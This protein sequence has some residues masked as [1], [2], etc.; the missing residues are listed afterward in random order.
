MN[1][2]Y[3]PEYKEWVYEETL[4]NGL[5]VLL[6]PKEDY[7]SSFAYFT[8]KFGGSYYG[9]EVEN[10]TLISGLAHFLEHRLFD[11]PKG[12]VMNLYD[13]LGA[14]T[15][16]YTSY[17]IT[18]YLFKTSKNLDK[19]VN[20]L[21]DFVQGAEFPEEKVENEKKIISQE[22]HLG[23]D[24]PMTKLYYETMKNTC[25][26]YP[27][28]E[29]IIG[30]LEDINSTTRELLYLAHR[31]FYHPTNM[32]LVVAGGFDPNKLIKVIRNN[33]SKKTFENKVIPQRNINESSKVGKKR[34][35]MT[36][37]LPYTKL[38]LGYKF[39]VFNYKNKLEE[40]KHNLIIEYIQEILFGRSSK[41]NEELLKDKVILNPVGVGNELN[42]YINA[43]FLLVDCMDEEKT[44][45]RLNEV[46]KNAPSYIDEEVFKRIK[47][48]AIAAS[49][50]SLDDV[51]T[52]AEKNMYAALYDINALDT[53][54]IAKN[55]T[56]EEV[57]EVAK[58]FADFDLS[59]NVLK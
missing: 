26:T 32:V 58:S 14:M 19:C 6:L 43:L 10:K 42:E 38:G 9:M 54:N 3:Y 27:L 46:M 13:S 21:L 53:I 48:A 18:T 25:D 28:K 49:I 34:T 59:I 29:K 45:S 56:Y 41:L 36:F 52:Y 11:Y 22:Y 17:D 15:N 55:I 47:K 35:E 4:P 5:K 50:S 2:K 31:T 20:L 51:E 37:G 8:T 12:N 44:V 39:K 24:N 40:Y 33:Q 1:K 57:I 7:S 16:A 30:S 23:N